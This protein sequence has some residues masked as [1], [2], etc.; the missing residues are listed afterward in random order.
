MLAQ[1]G[2][3]AKPSPR[4]GF[5]MVDASRD[6]AES[7]VVVAVHD[8]LQVIR[9]FRSALDEAMGRARD[10]LVLDYGAAPLRSQLDR[11]GVD[12]REQSALRAL[13]SNPH[14]RVVRV[15]PGEA[16]ITTTV[17]LCESLRA[18]L[19]ILA[20]DHIDPAKLDPGLIRQIFDGA[21][22]V[23]VLAE[24]SPPDPLHER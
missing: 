4:R 10:L 14:V 5:T 16:N 21:F 9:L 18:S 2:W 8:S 3:K 17:A 13:W 20:A 19:L 23:L 1:H 22:D 15:D 7:P 12:P 24:S 6:L 11:E